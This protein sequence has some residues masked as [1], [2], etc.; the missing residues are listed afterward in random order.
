MYT[1]TKKDSLSVL[2]SVYPHV[3]TV[4]FKSM[5]VFSSTTNNIK[6]FALIHL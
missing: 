2:I 3:V 6:N 4:N 5:Q 1:I